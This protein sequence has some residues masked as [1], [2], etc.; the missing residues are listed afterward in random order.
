[1]APRK[2]VLIVVDGLA[3]DTLATAIAS[4]AAPNLGMLVERG[5]LGRA[6]STFPSLTPVCLS[7]IATGAGPD[8]TRIPALQWYHR[9]E[10][11][12]VEYGSSFEATLVE[13]AKQ[14]VDDAVVN[15]NHVHLSPKLRTLFEAVE[16][17]GMIAAS[18]NFPVWRGRVRHS[19]KYPMLARFA[20]RT[21]F[22]D[23]A[24]GPSQFYFGELFA[25]ERTGAPPSLGVGGR[26]DANAA[27]VGRWLVA[28]DG[29]DFLLFYL[30][31]T[32]SA[33]HRGGDALRPAAVAGADSAIAT[34][35]SA[36]GGVEPFLERYAV[37]LCADHGQS[38]IDCDDDIR[39]AFADM[40]LFRARGRSA[41]ED[42]DLAVAASNR[43]GHV[44]RLTSEI[45]LREIGERLLAR[46][47]VDVAAWREDEHAVARHAGRELRF[48]PG[49][50]LLDARGGTWTLEGDRA[51]LGLEHSEGMLVSTSYPNALERLWQILG[52]VNAGDVVASAAPRYEFCDAG[53]ASHLGGGSHGSLHAVDSLVPLAAVGVQ[54]SPTLPRERSIEDIAA[55][56]AGHLGIGTW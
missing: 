23:A 7:T 5:D 4:G 53:G 32:D 18:V 55:L 54:D 44:Y 25:T 9:G 46:T 48:A 10:Q 16:D 27:A 36:A 39:D 34:L 56:C 3:P 35:M 6:V 28:R 52:C 19:F 37:V 8:R 47:S 15:L 1:V 50:P 43:A 38:P 29:F 21:G 33:G 41:P 12:F 30:P 14:S 17:A 51:T 26:N 13:G 42:C 31:E 40:R 2:L 45:P 11:R 49:G 22:M 20:R 24:Y